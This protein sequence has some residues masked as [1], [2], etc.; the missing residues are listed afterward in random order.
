MRTKMI[1][2][3][4]ILIIGLVIGG[5]FLLR[6]TDTVPEKRDNYT[7]PEAPIANKPPREAKEGYKWVLHDDHWAEVPIAQ[8]TEPPETP[9]DWD[10]VPSEWNFPIP[11][12]SDPRDIDIEAIETLRKKS[13]FWA[14]GIRSP[15]TQDGYID[16]ATCGTKTF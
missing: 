7:K 8:A 15:S 11:E 14:N 13:I 2:G 3:L 6:P 4:G 1:W 9:I 10:D 5:V 16:T 12:G